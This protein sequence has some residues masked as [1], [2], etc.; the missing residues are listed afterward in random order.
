M[1]DPRFTMTILNRLAGRRPE[2][3]LRVEQA[4]RGRLEELTDRC[5]EVAVETGDP[6]GQVMAGLVEERPIPRLV[7]P[8]LQA[9]DEPRFRNVVALREL[10][11]MV[12]RQRLIWLHGNLSVRPTAAQLVDLAWAH[13]NL[14]SRLAALGDWQQALLHHQEAAEMWSELAKLSPAVDLAA[15]ATNLVNL[16]Y[17][18]GLQR[19]WR[20]ALSTIEE[21]LPIWRRLA[22]SHQSFR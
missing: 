13:G 3:T 1:N 5:L 7:E 18:H 21:A 4:L 17:V 20:A 12:A 6:V 8:L 16:A 15:Q 19:D 10:A 2:E 22:A 14:A 9:C 11:A